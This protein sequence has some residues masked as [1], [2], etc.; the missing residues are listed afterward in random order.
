MQYL[1]HYQ[2]ILSLSFHF[3]P[4]RP[5][6]SYR[7]VPGRDDMPV[8]MS[9]FQMQ[10]HVLFQVSYQEALKCNHFRHQRLPV[11][12][13]NSRL[14]PDADNYRLPAGTQVPLWIHRI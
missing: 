11:P 14:G 10:R 12:V 3:C 9:D 4:Y 1:P 7:Q 13:Y 5:E 8:C 2:T 6:Q